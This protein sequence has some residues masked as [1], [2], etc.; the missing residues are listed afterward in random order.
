METRGSSE[1]KLGCQLALVHVGIVADAVIPKH[2]IGHVHAVLD[3][4]K[5]LDYLGRAARLN[6]GLC[7]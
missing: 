6:V 7:S 5:L 4:Q 2:I 1:K 3:G